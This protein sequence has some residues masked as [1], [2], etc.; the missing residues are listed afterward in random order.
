MSRFGGCRFTSGFKKC[1]P[2]HAP[3][4]CQ[5]HRSRASS[6]WVQYLS[7]ASSSLSGRRSLQ[8]AA[9]RAGNTL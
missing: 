1:C 8:G 9:P 4:G 3:P 6:S 7:C 2:V 5:V